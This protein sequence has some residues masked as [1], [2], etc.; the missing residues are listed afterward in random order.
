MTDSAVVITV[1]EGDLSPKNGQFLKGQNAK[2]TPSSPTKRACISHP[3]FS[4]G[5]ETE[6]Q[7]GCMCVTT[8]VQMLIESYSEVGD[9]GECVSLQR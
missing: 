2:Q 8:P 3:S 9:A 1:R 6:V 7:R 4:P 5:V